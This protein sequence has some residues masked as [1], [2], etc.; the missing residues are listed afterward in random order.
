MRFRSLLYVPASAERF[1]ANAHKRGADAIILDMEDAVAPEHKGAA[2]K[3]LPG[4]IS[5]AG[6]AGAHMFVR[7]NGD[8]ETARRDM[9]AAHAGGAFG[10]YVAKANV[11]KLIE[12]DRFLTVLEAG[13]AREP[14]R[15][16]ALI[17]DPA[18]VLMARDMARQSRMLALSLGSEDYATA[19]G[20]FPDP[21]VLRLPK[22][23]LHLAAKAHGLLSFGLVRTVADYSDLAAIGEAAREAKRHGFDGASCVHPSAIPILNAAFMPLQEEID[24]ARAV[25][26]KASKTDAGAFELDGHMVDAPVI[27]RARR[28]LDEI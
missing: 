12:I 22:Q 9:E 18:G 19:M 10:L 4:S 11:E 25:L 7:I 26:E 8:M 1:I 3:N 15:L 14:I 24:W 27:K 21:D 23:L 2:R 13:S 20:A 17:E 5:S 16:V 28:L 6:Q